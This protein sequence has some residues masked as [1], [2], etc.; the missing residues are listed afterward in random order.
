MYDEHE[1]DRAILRA[2]AREKGIDSPAELSRRLS[3]SE[4]TGWRLWTGK[5]AP[6]AS[7][8]ALVETHL[9]LSAADLLRKL[10]KRAAA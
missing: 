7:V 3:V 10:P 2:V 4:S 8:A 6:S 5:A 9:G 1:Y